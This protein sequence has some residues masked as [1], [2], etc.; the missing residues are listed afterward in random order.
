MG[1]SL[2]VE[3]AVKVF[4]M[5]WHRNKGVL[6]KNAS[7]VASAVVSPSAPNG[8]EDEDDAEEVR[9]LRQASLRHESVAEKK[10]Y[11]IRVYYE[12]L[13]ES[14]ATVTAFL[15]L[16]LRAELGVGEGF[17]RLVLALGLEYIAD[18][19]VWY[20]LEQNGYRLTNVVCQFGVV[21]TAMVVSWAL[22]ALAV[23]MIGEEMTA[24]FGEV[25]VA[26]V[27]GTNWTNATRGWGS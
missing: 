8:K 21:R 3:V 6:K 7:R 18:L 2:G 16:T 22:L 4:M 26:G 25:D 19:G 20:V 17:L 14:I 15:S 1:V 13:G 12:E 10:R 9:V 11:E 23:V 27:N 5:W 24:M